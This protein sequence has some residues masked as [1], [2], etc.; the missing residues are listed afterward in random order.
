MD[1][2]TTFSDALNQARTVIPGDMTERE[3]LIFA[4]G[5]NRGTEMV[6]ATAGRLGTINHAAVIAAQDEVDAF[7]RPQ[8]PA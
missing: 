5:Y 2:I 6:I 3:R 4:L 1:P 8:V 7:L